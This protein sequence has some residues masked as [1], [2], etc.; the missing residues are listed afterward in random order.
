MS[1]DCLRQLLTIPVDGG[2]GDGLVAFVTEDLPGRDGA[3]GQCR[4]RFVVRAE[5]F[6]PRA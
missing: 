3:V 2:M 6:S 5:F 4:V 1:T